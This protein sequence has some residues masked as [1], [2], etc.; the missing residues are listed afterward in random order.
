MK[1]GVRHK[2]EVSFELNE[3]VSFLQIRDFIIEALEAWGGQ[4]HPDDPLF[5]SLERVGVKS[6]RERKSK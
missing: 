6:I 4:F 5:G 3:T 1:A 2:V